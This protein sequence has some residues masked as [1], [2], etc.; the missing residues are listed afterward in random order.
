MTSQL[1]GIPLVGFF[2]ILRHILEP[3]FGETGLCSLNKVCLNDIIGRYDH[4]HQYLRSSQY[5]KMYHTTCLRLL[6]IVTFC[7]LAL[8]LTLFHFHFFLTLHN[9][10]RHMSLGSVVFVEPS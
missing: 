4:G 2:G 10:P 1:P 7:D 6:F 5:L 3:E 8:I 9:M